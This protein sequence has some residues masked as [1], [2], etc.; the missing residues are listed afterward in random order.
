MPSRRHAVIGL[1]HRA[2]LYVDALLGDW[3]DTGRLVA[4]CDTNRTRMAY[5]ADR[6]RAAGHPGVPCYG[7]EDLDTVLASADTVVV[8]S[9]D[10][11]HARYVCAALDAG[12]DVVVEKPLT[13]DEA[14]CA[15]IAEAAERSG[16]RLTVAF[17]YRYSPR[18]AAVRAL[19][20]EGRIG[21]VTAVHFEWMLDTV[22]GADYFRRWH[23]RRANSGGLLVHK[24]THHF[25]L[26][27]WWLGSH[28]VRVFAQTDRRFYGDDGAGAA[29]SAAPR[30][31]RAHRAPTLGR[32]PFLLDLSADP[33]LKALY[34]DAEHEDGYHRDLD[35]FGAGVD[36]DDTMS[37]L[38]RYGNRSVLTY[39]L[40]AYA[41][42]E[43]YRVAVTGTRGRLELEVCE[44]R[45]TPPGTALD[46]TAAG[47]QDGEHERL[48]VQEHWKQPEEIPIVRGEG[49]HGGGDALML[50]DLLR[51]TGDDPLGR[52]AGYRDGL[53]SVL[54][55]IAA[56]RSART[57]S[58]V[59][60]TD[61]GTRLAPATE[62]EASRP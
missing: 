8:T 43:G 40:T 1:G 14:G 21:E 44:R 36:I 16:G 49:G 47:G 3:S 38:V 59:A 13:V 15:R 5:Y 35:P 53:R 31:P 37:V 48:T 23:R 33:R 32:D 6:A 58:P 27:N 4:F 25:D 28:P 19:L 57:G 45:W 7:P 42:C 26:V 12:A 61:E 22:H 56:D 62:A 50:D 18:N 2:Q 17:N 39:S 46:S 20:A 60:L 55:G 9:P 41:P 24:S 10:A 34:L 51:G 29:R 30:P 52:R 54:T 11:T